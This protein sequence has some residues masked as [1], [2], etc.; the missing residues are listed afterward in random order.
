MEHAQSKY[1]SQLVG[2]RSIRIGVENAEIVLLE[3]RLPKMD[4]L[5]SRSQLV[6]I[7]N[8]LSEDFVRIA[9]NIAEHRA[10]GCF[11]DQIAAHQGRPFRSLAPA[12]IVRIIP[13]H[14]PVGNHVHQTNAWKTKYWR[15][16]GNAWTV[17]DLLDPVMA[18]DL[19]QA[20]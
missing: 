11:V 1:N 3:P 16:Q 17:Q 8:D 13:G 2:L 18:R 14:K 5:V 12:K 10:R 9:Q 15:L 20:Q 4:S 7:G 6:V 19:S